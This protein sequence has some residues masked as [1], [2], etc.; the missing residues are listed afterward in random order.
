M[1]HISPSPLTKQIPLRAQSVRPN[2]GVCRQS[3]LARIVPEWNFWSGHRDPEINSQ[4]HVRETIERMQISATS[5]GW[6]KGFR[7]CS[8]RPE[9]NHAAQHSFLSNSDFCGRC[10]QDSR[11]MPHKMQTNLLDS[12][13]IAARANRGSAEVCGASRPAKK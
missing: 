8:G 9:L 5:V 2:S 4:G 3:T 1:L 13:G 10:T 12:T 7:P 6:S 11:L